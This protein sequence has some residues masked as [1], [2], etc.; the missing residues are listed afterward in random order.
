MN[1]RVPILLIA[2]AA[3]LLAGCSSS[4]TSPEQTYDVT[5]TLEVE[6]ASGTAITDFAFDAGGSMATERALRFRW[7]WDSD[8][9]WDTGWSA[10]SV[11]DHRFTDGDTVAVT[12]QADMEGFRDSASAEIVID[13]RHGHI[14]E[15]FQ[16]DV[17][18]LVLGCHEGSLWAANHGTPRLYEVDAATGDTLHSIPAPSQWPCGICSDGENL[19]VSDYLGGT[20]IFEVDAADGTILSSFPVEYTAEASGLAWD[21]EYFYHPSWYAEGRGGD[22]L[23]HKYASDGGEVATFPCPGGS[24]EPEGIAYDGQDLWVV[25][26]GVDTLYVMSSEDGSVLR[27][28]PF[29]GSPRDIAVFG[30]HVWLLTNIQ[31]WVAQV[32]P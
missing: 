20:K 21:G 13:P 12:V 31:G 8:G 29:D 14:L 23:I 26:S 27:T 7:D 9:T 25:V 6:P 1:A 10:D 15:T 17:V 2:A 4:S 22:G 24:V 32:V 16:M 3:C 19:W 11:V 5:A 28:V 30:E 18:A